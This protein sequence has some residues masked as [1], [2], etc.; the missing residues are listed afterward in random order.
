MILQPTTRHL[1]EAVMYSALTKK[2]SSYDGI[3]FAAIKTTGIFCRPSCSAK[4]PLAQNVLYFSSVQDCLSAGY[5]ACK[6]CRPMEVAGAM[7]D[8]LSR[9]I[10]VLDNDPFRRWTNREIKELGSEPARLN[11]WFETNHGITFQKFLRLR[12]LTHALHQLSLGEDL[13]QVALNSGYQSLSGFREGFQNA[14]GIT[15]GAVSTEHQPI[16]INRILSPLGPMVIGADNDQ[17]L[18]LEFAD[19]RMLQ[20]QLQRLSKRKGVAIVPGE[21]KLMER[22]TKEIED[23]FYGRREQFSLRIGLVGTEFQK[24]VWAELL[25]IPFGQ[26]TS[27]EKIASA[28]G[29]PGASR[30]VGTANGDN[31]IAIIIPCHRVVRADG[32]LSGYGGSVWRKDWLLRHERSQ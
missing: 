3:F 12:R 8:W 25:K 23:Y 7:P 6:R 26:R 31:R 14:F 2:D 15:A 27:Y 20:T 32:T 30:A 1:T 17:L 22:A 24:A 28:V 16:L 4:K 13:T 11:R 19:R 5:R 21:C 10:E 29:V 9:L 18:M